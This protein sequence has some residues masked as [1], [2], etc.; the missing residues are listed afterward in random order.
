[1]KGQWKEVVRLTFKGPR[2]HDHALD[3]SAITE[4]SQ[5]QKI[6]AET[7]KALWRA[8][9]PERERLPKLFEDRTRLCLRKIEEGSAIAPLEVYI[10]EIEEQKDLFGPE[11]TEVE[12]SVK[13]AQEVYNRLEK[14]EPLPDNFPKLLIPDYEKWGQ[15]LADD[16]MIEFAT[17]GKEPARVTQL[18]RNRLSALSEVKHEDHVDL[19]G[20]VLEADIRQGKFQLWLDEKTYV[21]VIFSTEQEIIV[22]DSLRDHKSLRLQVIGRGEFSPQGKPLKI[23]QV[24]KLQYHPVGEVVY[25]PTARP[26]EEILQDLAKEV[27]EEEWKKLPTDLTDNLDHYIYGTPEK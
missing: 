15:G 26:I 17:D 1:M 16:E 21:S 7:A 8:A 12:E 25:D 22:L 10:E 18:S 4:L 2:F 13:L 14:D 9:N 11:P 5:F 24:D 20:E 19:I 27:P 6:V 3:L 23:T